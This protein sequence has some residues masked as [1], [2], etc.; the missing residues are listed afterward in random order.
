MLCGS[1][2]CLQVTGNQVQNGETSSDLQPQE[3][4]T[5]SKRA[6]S[7]VRGWEG[8]CEPSVSSGCASAGLFRGQPP[9]RASGPEYRGPPGYPGMGPVR[10]LRSTL[11]A[12]RSA[13]QMWRQLDL[14]SHRSPHFPRQERPGAPGGRLN[15]FPWFLSTLQLYLQCILY[16]S[17]LILLVGKEDQSQ[18]GL[19]LLSD[20]CSAAS[21]RV[22][23]QHPPHIPMRWK[24]RPYTL[25]TSQRSLYLSTRQT[26]ALLR[27]QSP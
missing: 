6:P 3:W 1:G 10:S 20:D 18:Q 11:H 13:T 4:S 8:G 25:R 9:Q 19:V 14:P 23:D 2:A 22:K 15:C 24:R 12:P 17:T 5:P 27:R 7:Q 21:S 26:W 16:N